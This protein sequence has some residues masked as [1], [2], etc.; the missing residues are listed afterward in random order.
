MFS[1][2]EC[3]RSTLKQLHASSRRRGPSLG[4]EQFEKR[5][6]LSVSPV[7]L[8]VT[9]VIRHGQDYDGS[10]YGTR[11][12]GW[13]TAL[14]TAIPAQT[15]L[16]A[17][18]S[19]QK[20]TSINVASASGFPTTPHSYSPFTIQIDNEIM[21]VTGRTAGPNN[22]TTWTVVRGQG[23]TTP[24]THLNAATVTTPGD[25]TIKPLWL[26]S[27][28]VKTPPNSFYT[29]TTRL[30][31]PTPAVNGTSFKLNPAG[32]LA[33]K[34]Y[35]TVLPKLLAGTVKG[36]GLPVFNAHPISRVMVDSFAR[37]NKQ[38]GTPNPL[39]TAL[40]FIIDTITGAPDKPKRPLDIDMVVKASSDPQ[41]KD[42][43]RH[44]NVTTRLKPLSSDAGS[45][46]IVSTVQGL[47][48]SDKVTLQDD[49]IIG[50]LN[51]KYSL[52]KTYRDANLWKPSPD[53][54]AGSFDKVI[55]QK[56]MTIYVYGE[57]N[58]NTTDGNEVYVYSQNAKTGSVTFLGGVKPSLNLYR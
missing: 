52:P 10:S 1:P 44:D 26:E 46:L 42:A 14:K 43:W 33:A 16:S 25:F 31:L 18:I 27:N 35:K 49:S 2:K 29:D 58:N 55:P 41:D 37:G 5:I 56:G 19:S 38:T 23:G 9:I 28:A 12:A 7:A 4:V 50:N 13:D 21:K 11:Q 53:E 34:S 15:K 8:P 17:P 6:A 51:Q 47:W 57:L 3:R 39:D 45:V 40:P 32:T 24:A 22:M 48:S 30:G 36:L 20:Q 54:G